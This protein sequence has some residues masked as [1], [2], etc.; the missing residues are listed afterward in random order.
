MPTYLV[1]CYNSVL[2]YIMSHNLRNVKG[3]L[4][5]PFYVQNSNVKRISGKALV[6]TEPR[7]KNTGLESF[8]DFRNNFNLGSKIN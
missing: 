1:I 7:L 4:A 8:D 2:T 5:L 3:Y 6:S